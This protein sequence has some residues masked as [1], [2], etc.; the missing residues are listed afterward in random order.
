MSEPYDSRPDTYEHVREVGVRVIA[1]AKNLLDRAPIHDQ[2]K[3]EEPE[4]SVF[5]EFTPM[6]KNLT[7][8]TDEYKAALVGMGEAVQHHYLMNRHHPE[9]FG[10]KGIAGM[11]LMDIIEMLADWKAATLR[12]KDGDLSKSIGINKDRFDISDQLF[13]VLM[14]TAIDLGWLE[15]TTE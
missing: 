7:Y 3:T 8:G 11:N 12:M 15:R 1:A 4:R 5:D 2:S 13:S 10:D 9:H 14:N 6:L